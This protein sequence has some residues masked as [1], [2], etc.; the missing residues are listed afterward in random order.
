MQKT[1]FDSKRRYDR[2]E[3]SAWTRDEGGFQLIELL[4]TLAL[5]SILALLA[6]PPMGTWWRHLSLELG[7]EQLAGA[8][9]LARSYAIRH[10]T[11]VA[12]RFDESAEGGVLHTLY[13]DGDGDGVRNDDIERG[14]DP[15]VR[16]TQPLESFGTVHYGFP[17]GPAPRDPG[18]R[19][20]DRLDD[21]IRFNRSNLAS[22]DPAG[23]ATPGTVYLTDGRHVL[24]AVRISSRTSRVRVLR[25]DP[26]KERW[27]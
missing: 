7:A 4:V 25:Y 20:M 13:R 5:I 3:I 8:M 1:T 26:V 23:T 11:R 2:Q 24:F 22:F 17:P 14:V 10:N 27:Y 16:A 12:L 18:G 6:A 9:Q 21:P 15:M 19:R